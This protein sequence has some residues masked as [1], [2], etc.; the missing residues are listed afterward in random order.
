MVNNT[1]LSPTRDEFA[2]DILQ[3]LPLARFNEYREACK[4][5]FPHAMSGHHYLIVQEHWNQFLS[6]PTNSDVSK[7]I[8]SRCKHRVYAHRDGVSQNCTIIGITNEDLEEDVSPTKGGIKQ[9]SRN[10]RFFFL[11]LIGLYYHVHIYAGR[12]SS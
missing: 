3:P 4:S 2:D 12:E 11:D 1:S 7:Q 6:D 9:G 5:N 8:S 10:N